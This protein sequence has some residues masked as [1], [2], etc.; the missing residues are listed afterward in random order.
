MQGRFKVADAHA[1]D[2]PSLA[3]ALYAALTTPIISEDEENFGFSEEILQQLDM[4]SV[5]G[6]LPC[7]HHRDIY[8]QVTKIKVE[9]KIKVTC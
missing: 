4:R 6:Y 9:I 5:L 8:I 7:N 3:L 2:T 1:E